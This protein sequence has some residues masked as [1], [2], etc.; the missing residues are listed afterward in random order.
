MIEEGAWQ[1]PGARDCFGSSFWSTID[2]CE[3]TFFIDCS[4]QGYP[5][6]GTQC[7]CDLVFVFVFV[8]VFTCKNSHLRIQKKNCTSVLSEL[9]F[10][11]ESKRKASSPLESQLK[12]TRFSPRL[13]QNSSPQEGTCSF[14]LKN[15]QFTQT[16]VN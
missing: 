9:S 13:A 14:L 16:L 11:A 2:I 10:M 5:V 1:L 4:A 12:A 6:L 8:F 7:T 15:F 3:L